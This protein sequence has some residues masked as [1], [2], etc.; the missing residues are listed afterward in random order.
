MVGQ[1]LHI[2]PVTEDS[3][4]QGTQ[5]RPCKCC[6]SSNIAST[7]LL[8]PNLVCGVHSIVWFTPHTHT[9]CY[10]HNTLWSVIHQT[11]WCVSNHPCFS[12]D[13]PLQTAA[14]SCNNVPFNIVTWCGHRLPLSSVAC[15]N[16]LS[17]HI[18]D[19]LQTR[20]PIHLGDSDHSSVPSIIQCTFAATFHPTVSSFA[21]FDVLLMHTWYD[22]SQ[23]S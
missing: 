11:I 8:F 10:Q 2:E 18:C 22:L 15:I 20:L 21:R 1:E 14:K 7:T 5:A 16:R 23:N 17:L 13:G 9:A 4:Y 6:P 19:L 3:R 12:F